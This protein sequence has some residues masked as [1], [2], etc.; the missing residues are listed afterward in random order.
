MSEKPEPQ[1]SIVRY[2]TED[3]DTRIECA[4]ITT[5]MPSSST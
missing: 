4:S 2:Q 3:G 1:T 5:L